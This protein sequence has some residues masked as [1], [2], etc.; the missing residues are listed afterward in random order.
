MIQMTLMSTNVFELLS[1]VFCHHPSRKIKKKLVVLR[2]TEVILCNT[3]DIVKVD[4]ISA[5]HQGRTQRTLFQYTCS[6]FSYI[7]NRFH[8]LPL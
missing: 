2:N 4:C 7:T 3:A 6:L 8:S 5:T 1:V